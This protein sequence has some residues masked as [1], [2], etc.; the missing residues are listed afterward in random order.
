MSEAHHNERES[1]FGAAK[2]IAALTMLSRVLGLVRDM[3]LVPMGGGMLADRFWTAFSVPNL[4]RRLFGEGA[5][6]A[7]FVPVFTEVAETEGWDRA[8]VVLA[9]VAGVL[10]AI[11][12]G[13]IVLIVAGLWGAWEIWGGDWAR[14]FLLQMTALMMPFMLTV[15]LLALGSAA[16]NCRGHFAYPAFAPVLLNVG[17]I[18]AAAWIAPALTRND[19]GQFYIIGL[20]L[21]ATGIVQVVGVVW[22]LRRAGLSVAPRLR[23]LLPEVK[24]IGKL[25][26]PMILPLSILQLSAF[27]DRLIALIFTSTPDAPLAAG[28]VRCLYAASRLYMLPMGVL[29]IPVATVVFPLLGR[30]AARSDTAGLRE[31]TNRAMRLCLFLG[32]PAAVALMLLAEDIIGLIYQRRGFT[33]FD[34]DRA[35][36]MLRMYCLGLWAYFSNQI[37]LRAFFAIKETRKPLIIACI[38]VVLNL[39]LVLVGIHTPLKGAAIGL[40]TAITQSINALLLIWC[41]RRRWGRIGL[42]RIGVSLLRI[43]VATGVMAAVVWAT[44]AYL[45]SVG[46]VLNLAITVVA[47]SGAYLLVAKILR[48]SELA[49]LKKQKI[50]T[51]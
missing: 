17:L 37:L 23:P 1:F 32:I 11:L 50:P 39:A 40:A 22:L 44:G 47:G 16:L 12:A 41:L 29:A 15:C 20:A 30:Y 24:S 43:A 28:V 2:L 3:L 8:R 51:Q 33:E 26:G 42:R 36:A 19:E 5:L 48:C 9:N 34:T 49:E 46:A 10:A 21:L 13:L 6:S 25:M 31:T 14:L 38:L 45:P 7:A 18:V 27:A 35:A 4:F